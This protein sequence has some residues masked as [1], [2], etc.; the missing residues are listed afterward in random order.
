M[1]VSIDA[2]NAV[3]RSTVPA[4]FTSDGKREVITSLHGR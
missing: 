3:L 2:G 1:D 4:W